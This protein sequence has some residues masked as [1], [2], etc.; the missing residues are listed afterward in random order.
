MTT[1]GVS[2]E[3]SVIAREGRDESSEPG[4][5]GVAL[6]ETVGFFGTWLRLLWRHW[7]VL[8]ALAF[9]GTIARNLLIDQAYNASSWRDGLG[10]FLVFPLVPL[11]LLIPMV[12]MLRVMRPSLP[13][14]GRRSRP[15]PMLAY[16]ASVLIPFLV[17]Y[18][19]GGYYSFDGASFA[20]QLGT[21]GYRGDLNKVFLT[22]GVVILIVAAVAFVLRFVLTRTGVVRRLPLLF[23]VAAYLETLWLY[24]TLSIAATYRPDGE[25]WVENSRAWQ[26]LMTWWHTQVDVSSPVGGLINGARSAVNTFTSDAAPVLLAP[27]AA[28]V[29]GSVVLAARASRTN[30]AERPAS[31]LGRVIQL[32]AEVGRPVG[33]RL[34]LFA[35]GLR[36]VFQAGVV[37]TMIFCL[38]YVA[39]R[40]VSSLLILLVRELVG[41]RDVH[42]VWEV[43]YFPELF[44]S[45]AIELVLVMALIAAFVDRTA[46]RIARRAG[47]P[48]RTE[49]ATPAT[50]TGSTFPTVAPVFLVPEQ[51]TMRLAPS[52]GMPGY[53]PPGHGGPTYTGPVVGGAVPGTPSFGGITPVT[54][55][56]TTPVQPPPTSS[57]GFGPPPG[58]PPPP[59]GGLSTT[60]PAG[61]TSGVWSD[62]LGGS[63]GPGT[64][65]LRNRDGKPDVPGKPVEPGDDE[66]GW[67]AFGR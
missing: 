45:D 34:A 33:G 65:R 30:R 25:Q 66:R 19:A 6:K 53:G 57:S 63:D 10:G 40:T 16:L 56:Y 41:P 64:D 18:T 2:A 7:P 24:A 43:L 32:G 36:R 59:A 42:R 26:A 21:A 39:L 47:V 37:G 4:P 61:L 50:P 28:L 9:A 5:L 20:Y 58:L 29:A 60:P 17:F 23:L 62:G 8:L 15:E 35:D 12:L 44:A 67:S 11:A 13:Y 46:A 54:A 1:V 3:P 52:G 27:V 49:P 31:R 48:V 14:L 55:T 22:G 38:A 51:S